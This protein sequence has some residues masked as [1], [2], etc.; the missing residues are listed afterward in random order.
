MYINSEIREAQIEQLASDPSSIVKGRIW[1]QGT[2][3]IKIFDGTQTHK[4]LTDKMF[5][6]IKEANFP[7]GVSTLDLS[8]DFGINN[9]AVSYNYGFSSPST[10]VSVGGLNFVDIGSLNLSLSVTTSNGRPAE[11]FLTGESIN[12]FDNVNAIFVMAEIRL[13][14]GTDVVGTTRIGFSNDF[15]LNNI[16]ILGEPTP[17]D[18]ASISNRYGEVTIPASSIRFIDTPPGEGT[19]TYKLQAKLFNSTTVLNFT[20]ARLYAKEF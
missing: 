8:V 4:V 15:V 7:D 6:E 2:A 9:T 3:P 1:S 17:A 11:I 14:R 12:I 16:N 19:Y 13:L 18:P 20:S 10:T 5:A